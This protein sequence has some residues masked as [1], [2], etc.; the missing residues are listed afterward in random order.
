VLRAGWNYCDITEAFQVRYEVEPAR[1]APGVYRNITGN[2]ALALGFIAA[3]RKSGL[4][5]FQGA[6][7]ITPASD[8][9][10]ELA[11]FKQFGVTTFQAEDEIAAVCAAIG[12]AFG[13]ALALT[14]TS[15]PGLALKSEAMNLAVMTELPLVVVDI[16]RGGPSTGLPTKTEQADL[17]QALYG[18]NGESPIPVLA[19][20][21]PS[22]CFERAIE[23]CRWATRYMTP[24][25]LL[26]DG[27]LANGAEPWRLP[28]VEDLPDFP[29]VSTPRR[30]ISRRTAATPRRWR[31]R[32]RSPAR[33]GSSTAS[34]ASR[35]RTAR[36]PSPTTRRTTSA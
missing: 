26:S 36:A 33:R 12:A 16:Q 22:D 19:A 35:S 18:R 2:T 6:Y 5:L 4:P 3:S 31:G 21:S 25:L 9:L 17:L 27:Y 7:P 28:A 11:M 34:A 20:S 14:S 29:A 10:H 23:A 1:L 8:L 13:G 24:V 15:G 32:G 30:T